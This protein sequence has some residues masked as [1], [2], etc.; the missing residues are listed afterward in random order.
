MAWAKLF[1]KSHY[2]DVFCLEFLN[3]LPEAKVSKRSLDGF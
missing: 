2:V 1:S 3:Y